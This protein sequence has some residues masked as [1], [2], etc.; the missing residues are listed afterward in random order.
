MRIPLDILSVGSVSAVGL[1]ALQTAAAFRARIAG[2]NNAYPLEPP[3][4]PLTVAKVPVQSS[5]RAT[6]FAWLVNMADRVIREALRS[7]S[8]PGRIALILA[9]PEKER[10]HPALEG[11]TPGEFVATVC[12]RIRDPRMLQID[13][14]DIGGAGIA[15][16]LEIAE[17]LL[18]TGKVSACL[19]GGVDSLVN[20]EDVNRLRAA[21]RVLEPGNPKG[22]IPGE[23]AAAV[24]VAP[25]GSGSRP[26]ATIYGVGSGLEQ[27]PVAG[28]RLSQGR[29]FET[30]LRAAINDGGIP[31]SAI[32]F[33]VSGVNGEH[34]S[35]W[36][37]Q[38][39]PARVYRS[40]REF[41]PA[42]Y[43]ASSFGDSG[44]A[45]GVLSIVLAAAGI[46]GGYAPGPYGMCESAS[47]SGFRGAC[48]IGPAN[49]M[50]SPPFHAEGGA[51][52]R[53]SRCDS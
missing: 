45:S 48:L 53:I 22:L 40:R 29:G 32:S 27:N 3:Q 44:A 16:G 20:R 30:A 47:E 17:Y 14:V 8:A 39:Y 49:G 26:M 31:E 38:F 9:L 18:F 36:E 25:G 23:G 34:Y 2:F 21:N 37:S 28:R 19:V 5:L 35:V 7:Y 12:E 52:S 4:E 46:A 11:R 42:W 6:E 13:P 15:A 51:S 24:L 1:D 10:S 41:F 33:R 50:P 43:T